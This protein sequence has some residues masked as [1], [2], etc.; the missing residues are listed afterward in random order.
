MR[1]LIPLL[2]LVLVGLLLAVVSGH[3]SSSRI[4]LLRYWSEHPW[5]VF[6]SS[7]LVIGVGMVLLALGAS[8]TAGFFLIC[9]SL[10]IYV[11]AIQGLKVTYARSPR[12]AAIV[13]MAALLIGLV[14]PVTRF[15]RSG[16]IHRLDIEA[17]TV[18]VGIL[19]WILLAFVAQ[20]YARRI[21]GRQDIVPGL[22]N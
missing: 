21:L 8:W 11:S 20:R 4:K 14:N 19:F 13:V 1:N 2:I 7:Y 5:R 15:A 17:I 18:I 9:G 3:L 12:R 16:D 6:W 10:I 22:P